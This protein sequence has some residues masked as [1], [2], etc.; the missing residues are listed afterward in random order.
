[1]SRENT[2]SK[3]RL[4]HSRGWDGCIEA[5]FLRRT[6]AWNNAPEFR[7]HGHTLRRLF[8]NVKSDADAIDAD[9][10][11][12]VEGRPTVCIKDGRLLDN[13]KVEGTRR[14][15]WNLRA[16]TLLIVERHGQVQV[17]ST[18]AKP[19]SEDSHGADAQ[20]QA[21]TIERLETAD[22]PCGCDN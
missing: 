5:R 9:A 18:F 2:M 3:S 16:T 14:K 11:L 1:M 4:L 22:S 21:E 6:D 20:I 10:V 17:F 8:D 12:C 13:T 15:L 19:A 7:S